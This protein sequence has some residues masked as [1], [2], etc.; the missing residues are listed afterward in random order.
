MIVVVRR[1][2]CTCVLYETGSPFEIVE[3]ASRVQ[4]VEWHARRRRHDD[5]EV[6]VFEALRRLEHQRQV[7]EQR[8]LGRA[9]SVRWVAQKRRALVVHMLPGRRPYVTAGMH[10]RGGGGAT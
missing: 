10:D 3:R 9:L 4:L 7:A 2:V 8:E 5:T 1:Y 6:H